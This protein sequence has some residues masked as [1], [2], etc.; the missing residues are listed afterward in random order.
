MRRAVWALGTYFL[1]ATSV[2]ACM[3]RPAS[4]AMPGPECARS[5]TEAQVYKVRDFKRL[6]PPPGIYTIE[7]Y[8]V[9]YDAGAGTVVVSDRAPNELGRRRELTLF[10]AERRSLDVGSRYRLDVRV[11][12]A[13]SPWLVGCGLSDTRLASP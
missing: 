2:L 1:T 3:G 8:V 12:D 7:G 10:V 6:E 13:D 9:S 11:Q 5:N 4:S